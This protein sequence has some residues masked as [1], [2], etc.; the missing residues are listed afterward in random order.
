MRFARSLL[1]TACALI[2]NLTLCGPL[3]SPASAEPAYAFDPVATQGAP[4]PAGGTY[5]ASAFGPPALNNDGWVAFRSGIEG[6]SATMGV[7][8]SMPGGGV[9]AL[10]LDG[11]PA[12][13]G[14]SFSDFLGLGMD[15]AGRV[16]FRA[17]LDAGEVDEAIFRVDTL[18][19]SR[20]LAAGDPAP[21]GGG[22]LAAL[23]DLKVTPSGRVFVHALAFGGTIA[24]G[25]LMW[26]EGG[27]RWAV[28][29]GQDVPDAGR[30][31]WI[32][33]YAVSDSGHVAFVGRVEDDLGVS[34]QGLFLAL[35]GEVSRVMAP[36]D[37]TPMGG[38][39]QAFRVPTV[40]DL[41]HVAFGASVAGGSA[42]VGLFLLRDGAVSLVAG[43]GQPA[44][45]PASGDFARFER[46][47]L[48]GAGS[49]RFEAHLSGGTTPG[50]IFA[51]SDGV[52]APVVLS[53]EPAP[54]G[55]RLF[56]PRLFQANDLGALAF[57]AEV[58]GP[59]PGG[60]FLQVPGWGIRAVARLG[61]ATPAGGTYADP[62][63]IPSVNNAGEVA[64]EAGVLG[65]IAPEGIFIRG[66]SGT[67]AVA[68]WGDPAP[69]TIGGRLGDLEAP[70]L[71]SGGEVAFLARLTDS[72]GPQGIFLARPQEGSYELNPLAV[73]GQ[74]GPGG[75]L[76]GPL[77]R[78]EVLGDGAVLFG[79]V[80]V[81]AE[82]HRG[83]ILRCG[84][85]GVETLVRQGD[86]A[87]ADVGGSL[88][89]LGR[90]A[91]NAAG[92]IL[93]RARV[94]GGSA[95]AGLFLRGVTGEIRTLAADG[96]PT[97]LG[98]RFTPV[99]RSYA[100][101][102][103][104]EAVF[105]APV[106]GG[107]SSQ[108][109][110]RTR[111]GPV[112]VLAAEGWTGPWGGRYLAFG[113]VTTNSASDVAFHAALQ[114]GRKSGIYIDDGI[115]GMRPVVLGG[116]RAPTGGRFSTPNLPMLND[117]GQV[118]FRALVTGKAGR[119]GIFLADEIPSAP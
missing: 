24:D 95:R 108:A 56:H 44:P 104:G 2:L 94:R 93:F 27:A 55:G 18:S 33:E 73:V 74:P 81:D 99:F 58:L 118:V 20:L 110:F 38:V 34:S 115:H 54:G 42:P 9:R 51:W 91:G 15:D 21:D 40:N 16:V 10:A 88:G 100:L 6:A 107:V 84:P 105:V 37:P 12:P 45:A 82:G 61:Q 41:G 117:L 19:I 103:P 47:L 5:S 102:A 92:E 46:P 114:P 119:R 14:G 23:L 65:G 49:I 64:F 68:L 32:G 8:L 70:S 22:S 71:G 90:P 3:A 57:R 48:D 67:V 85:G 39:F 77:G 98:G 26:D 28:H 76:Y 7:F 109:V 96:S 25:I 80:L 83:A 36:G 11:Q 13:G 66:A 29:R 111:G 69:A 1:W 79:A 87:P 86:P 75:A 50:G 4:T 89:T 112:E 78:P 53:L 30:L 113:H 17:L 59:K 116:M 60:I 31:V 43:Q 35:E 97:P 106:S 72:V 101:G 52:L 62:S 63:F